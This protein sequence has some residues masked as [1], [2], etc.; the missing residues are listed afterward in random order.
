[1]VVGAEVTSG[2]ELG[3]LMARVRGNWF[4]KAALD[5]AWWD[6]FGRSRGLPVWQLAGGANPDVEIGADIPLQSNTDAL[7]S[8][9]GSAID[10]GYKRAKLKVTREYSEAE[11]GRLRE[12]FPDTALHVD[13]NGAFTLDDLPR[14]MALDAFGFVMIE[15]P[16]GYDDLVDHASLQHRLKTPICLDES[17]TSVSRARKAIETGACGWIN[18]KAGR[19]GGITPALAIHRLCM[20]RGIP[21]WIGSMLDSDLGQAASLALATLPNIRYPA[22]IFPQ[23]TFYESDVCEPPMRLSGP[24]LMRA[25]SRSGLGWQPNLQVLRA[26]LIES[27]VVRPRASF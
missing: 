3:D 27:T 23:G 8:A 19:V 13:C 4:A 6:A 15:Q 14:L 22:D 20:E 16:L 5:V 18:I 10:A 26:Q 9:V 12:R 24:S 17:I 21:N 11:L 25:P 7:I 1:M 2:E